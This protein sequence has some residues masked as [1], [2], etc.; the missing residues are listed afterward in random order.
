M[1]SESVDEHDDNDDVSEEVSLSVE[2][3]F[4]GSPSSSPTP[5]FM[6]RKRNV[7]SMASSV[8][9]AFVIF[10]ASGRGLQSV[11]ESWMALQSNICLLGFLTGTGVDSIIIPK[12]VLV[13]NQCL[14]IV[15]CAI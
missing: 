6:L 2:L 9:S 14:K 1:E 8:L 3:S 11:V 4:K 13:F 12:E 10:L 15:K 5:S 7:E